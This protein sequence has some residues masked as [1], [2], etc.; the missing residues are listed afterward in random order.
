MSSAS[1]MMSSSVLTLKRLEAKKIYPLSALLFPAAVAPRLVA[2]VVVVLLGQLL[3]GAVEYHAEQPLARQRL[4][5]SFE[6]GVAR[7]A[8]ARD[9]ERRVGA[10]DEHRRVGEDAERRRVDDDVVEHAPR[11]PEDGAELR[12]REHLGHVVAR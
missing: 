8:R 11:L 2:A 7:P 12:P 6:R 4:E 5:Q 10:A 3:V 1:A 9:D